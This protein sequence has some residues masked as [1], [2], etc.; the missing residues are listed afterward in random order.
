M[1]TKA[2]KRIEPR[3]FTNVGWF[4]STDLTS[5]EEKVNELVDGYNEIL[6]DLLKIIKG[7]KK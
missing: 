3:I 2:I 1:T 6:S 5:V 7:E 4:A